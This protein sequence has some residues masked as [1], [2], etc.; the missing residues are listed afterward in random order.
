MLYLR[1]AGVLG[2]NELLKTTK[3]TKGQLGTVSNER[4]QVDDRK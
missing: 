4:V 2:Y 3:W 1:V